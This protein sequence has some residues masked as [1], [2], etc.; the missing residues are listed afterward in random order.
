MA[1]YNLTGLFIGLTTFFIIGVFHPI[2]IKVEYHFGTRCWWC[3]LLFGVVGILL[4]IYCEKYLQNMFLS[5]IFGVFA[6]T[7]FWT[8]KELFEQKKRVAKGWFPKKRKQ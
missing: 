3:F 6:F 1:D 5:A 2:V 7:S 8:I 4:S